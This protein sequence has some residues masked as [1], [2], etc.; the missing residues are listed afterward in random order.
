MLFYYSINHIKKEITVMFQILPNCV[1][2]YCVNTHTTHININFNII[3][4]SFLNK[5]QMKK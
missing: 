5:L 1:N 3:I 4:I 2:F